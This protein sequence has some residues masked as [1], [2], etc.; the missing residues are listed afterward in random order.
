MERGAVDRR[1]N[2]I[3][4]KSQSFGN[5]N[6]FLEYVTLLHDISNM[7]TFAKPDEDR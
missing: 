7:I 1:E 3:L 6:Y 2:Y 4:W 5:N